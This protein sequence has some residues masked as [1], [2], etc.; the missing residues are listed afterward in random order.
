MRRLF[1]A[2]LVGGLLVLAPAA[3]GAAPAPPSQTAETARSGSAPAGGYEAFH[4]DDG[5]HYQ[6]WY[7]CSERRGRYSRYR[8]HHH[9][10][11][12]HGRYGWYYGR[13]HPRSRRGW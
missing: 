4:H 7:R 12:Y 3:A 10:C 6:C 2:M 5:G 1:T 9:N 13:C 11:W 8:Y